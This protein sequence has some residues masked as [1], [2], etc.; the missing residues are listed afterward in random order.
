VPSSKE[1]YA[2]LTAHERDVLAAS[3][4]G[5]GVA[6]VA[7]RLGLSVEAVRRSITSAIRKLDARSKLEAVV[8]ALRRGLI[9]LSVV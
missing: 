1:A 6:E 2:G 3:A 5:L 4:T 7:E 9:S 8:V